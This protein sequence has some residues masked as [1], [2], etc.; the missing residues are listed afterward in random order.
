MTT[1]FRLE[2]D[3][4][5]I[6]VA[7]FERY[8]NHPDLISMLSGMPAFRSRDLVEKTE[9]AE[10]AVNW[11]FKVVASS[12]IPA[13]AQRL[14][15]GD[16]LTWHE[17][18]RFVPAEHNIYWKIT[19]LQD[20]VR[21][22]LSAHGTWKLIPMGA[23][24]KRIID[25]NVDVKVPL[26]GKVVELF[27]KTELTKNYEVEPEIQRRFYLKMKAQDASTT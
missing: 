19:P 20:T 3:F 8:L 17:D 26:V 16:V 5:E 7:L 4:P 21:A 23:G 27:L 10:G 2:H 12:K 22:L 24:T 9:L 13:A 11:R 14:F 6:S 25:G 1:T 18:A 15:A